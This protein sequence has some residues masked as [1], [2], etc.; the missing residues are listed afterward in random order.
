[1]DIRGVIIDADIDVTGLASILFEDGKVMKW[2]MRGDDDI[3]SYL[4]ESFIYGLNK[5]DRTK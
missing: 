4:I 2:D 3:H 5:K 1:M